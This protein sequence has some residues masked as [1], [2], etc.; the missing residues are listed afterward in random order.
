MKGEKKKDF[1]DVLDFMI[2]CVT[3][4]TFKIQSILVQ[5]YQNSKALAGP[6][7]Q[8]IKIQSD[9]RLY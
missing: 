5:P 6:F 1:L 2:F 4:N 7:V 3:L 9:A 8:Y